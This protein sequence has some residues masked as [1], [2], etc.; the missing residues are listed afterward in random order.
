MT[1]TV[2]PLLLAC[3]LLLGSAAPAWADVSRDEAAATAQRTTSG[4][5]L[6]VD[7]TEANR[8][9]AWR[10]KVLTSQGD[11]RVIVIDAASGR[12]VG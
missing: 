11:V 10:V 3:A 9:P 2:R 12:I 8:R 4:R 5:V 7:K 1:S 6:S